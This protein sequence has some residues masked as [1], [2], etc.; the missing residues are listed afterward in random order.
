MN[1]KEKKIH[2]I[3]KDLDRLFNQFVKIIGKDDFEALWT[4]KL[5]IKYID[6]GNTMLTQ[7]MISK[8][9]PKFEEYSILSK[10]NAECLFRFIPSGH[11]TSYES[12]N[13]EAE[14]LIT[15]GKVEKW[16]HWGGAVLIS[17]QFIFSFFGLPELL[18]ETF[19]CFLG[20]KSGLMSQRQFGI[21]RKKRDNNPYLDIIHKALK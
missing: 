18:N 7:R 5:S 17:K 15:P 2:E 11:V 3:F 10:E 1:G 14:I 12:R 20:L 4:G 9:H 21:I 6:N 16:G 8:D 19:V 13:P